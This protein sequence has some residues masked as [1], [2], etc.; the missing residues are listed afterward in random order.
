MSNWNINFGV[1]PVRY[2]KRIG[3]GKKKPAKPE[4]KVPRWMHVTV[5]ALFAAIVLFCCCGGSIGRAL[6]FDV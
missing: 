5:G 6:G 3:G 2:N 4:V 1:G